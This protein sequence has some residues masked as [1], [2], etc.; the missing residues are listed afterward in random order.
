LQVWVIHPSTTTAVLKVTED[1]RLNL[2]GG[3]ATVLVMLDFTQ[4][5]DMIAHDLMVCKMRASQRYSDRATVLLGSYLSDQTQCVRS[6]GEYSTVRGIEYFK[7]FIQKYNIHLKP[8]GQLYGVPQGSVLGTLLFIS[9]IDDV[10]GVIHFCRF[11][12]YDQS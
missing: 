10:H 2:E 1:I 9:C 11:H 8:K 12:I 4:V 6:D 3:Q 5:F 7:H